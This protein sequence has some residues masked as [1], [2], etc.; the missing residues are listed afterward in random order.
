MNPITIG[1]EMLVNK[2][3]SEATKIN[4]KAEIY[5]THTTGNA[6]NPLQYDYKIKLAKEAF[7][8]IIVK[9]R[10]RTILD[11]VKSYNGIYDSIVLMVG[12]SRVRDFRNLINKYNGIKYS[13]ETINV[14]SVGDRDPDADGIAGVSA[15][16]M[17]NWAQQNNIKEFEKGLPKKIKKRTK[18]I[19]AEI[20][21][22]LNEETQ[23]NEKTAV[24][25]SVQRIKR[26]INAKRIR[27]KLKRA[28]KKASLRMAT[29]KTLSK[30]A[31]RAARSAVKGKF[32]GSQGKR[33]KSLSRSQKIAV[34][35][36]V[37]NRTAITGRIAKK[38]KIVVRRKEKQRLAR[39]RS[40]R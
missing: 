11:I 12:G 15:T 5:L 39:K 28:R 17:R 4:S 3:K 30:R 26:A 2:V 34:D 25:T 23:L 13:F 20:N 19:M 14:L 8:P 35:R 22:E 40:G 27:A 21:K 16:K 7:G 6:N 1:H 18:E 38:M 33:Y 32:A 31:R 9:S 36:K 37:A 10:H 24:L 29:G